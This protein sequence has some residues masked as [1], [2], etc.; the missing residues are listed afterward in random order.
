MF[1]VFQNFQMTRHM[2]W[3]ILVPTTNNQLPITN[4]KVP[5]RQG[6]LPFCRIVLKILTDLWLVSVILLHKKQ[7]KQIL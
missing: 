3:V 2:L 4:Y 7:F 6:R 5:L 1:P